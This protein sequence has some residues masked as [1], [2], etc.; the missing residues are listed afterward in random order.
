MRYTFRAPI[1]KEFWSKKD[2]RYVSWFWS[3]N[4]YKSFVQN[5]K[6]MIIY[7]LSMKFYL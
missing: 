6:K 1:V 7:K 5:N 3:S 2:C 4:V